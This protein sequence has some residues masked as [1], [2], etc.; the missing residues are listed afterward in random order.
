MKNLV[1]ILLFISYSIS[2]SQNPFGGDGPLIKNRVYT[3]LGLETYSTQIGFSVGPRWKLAG[4]VYFLD[5]YV[6][7]LGINFNIASLSIGLLPNSSF[8]LA[9]PGV[10]PSFIFRTGEEHGLEF[11]L[12]FGYGIYS[13]E[14]IVG[15]G[16]YYTTDLKWRNK[17]WAF[18]IAYNGFF[19]AD[20]KNRDYFDSF[21][22][23]ACWQFSI[24]RFANMTRNFAGVV[25]M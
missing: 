21:A 23:T 4:N 2:F 13:N 11:N 18:G 7:A 12:P 8:Q 10:G 24:E 19:N 14:N 9:L 22:L 16:L 1:Y 6:Y 25:V 17:D 20:K 5:R 3:E 15:G